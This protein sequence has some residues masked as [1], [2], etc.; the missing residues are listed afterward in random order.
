M[1]VLVVDDTKIMRVIIMDIMIK[2]LKFGKSSFVEASDGEEAIEQFKLVR[3]DLVFLD[4]KMP[5]GSGKEVV[6]ELIDIDKEA[7]IIMCTSSASVGDVTECI[8]A[9]A[10]DYIVKPVTPSRVKDAVK[11][12]LGL[13]E[14]EGI[15][16][17][18]VRQEK[19]AV[20]EAGAKASAGD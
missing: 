16:D 4:I 14:D 8:S 17:W 9:G 20:T 3:P 19:E 18:I 6:R 12:V 2:H 1:K 10:K 15:Y 11:K 13:G 7:N 5:Y